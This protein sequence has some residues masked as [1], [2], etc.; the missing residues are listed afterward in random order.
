MK[1]KLKIILLFLLFFI[2]SVLIYMVKTDK[3]IDLDSYLYNL[4]SIL[5]CDFLTDFFKNITKFA[6]FNFIT[7][8]IIIIFIVVKNKWIGILL[9]ANSI[10]GVIINKILKSI[11]VRPRPNVLRLIKQGGYSFP[12]GHAMA[13][14]IFYGMIIYLIYNT[15]IN[16]KLKIIITILLSLVIFFV[17]LSRVYLGVHYVSDIISGYLFSFIY[18]IIFIYIIKKIYIR[19][20]G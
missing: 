3:I 4:I 13:S 20:K 18:L 15:K 9:A 11:F 19:N 2:L 6:N 14:F 12:S 17:G 16:R 8:F 7:I 10:N 1:N 5:R